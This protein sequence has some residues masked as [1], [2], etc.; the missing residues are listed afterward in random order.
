M[1]IVESTQWN[2]HNDTYL[3]IKSAPSVE[4]WEGCWY[5]H[6]VG[7][8]IVGGAFS[9][10]FTEKTAGP[11]AQVIFDRGDE[12]GRSVSQIEQE[13]LNARNIGFNGFKTIHRNDVIYLSGFQFNH[14]KSKMTY[15]D[16]LDLGDRENSWLV[17]D[18][19]YSDM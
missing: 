3:Y 16:K 8:V 18:P 9:K 14:Y 1:R 17:E 5:R 13:L 4:E 11:R 19:L 12:K 7:S 6:L 15:G 10:Q 2:V